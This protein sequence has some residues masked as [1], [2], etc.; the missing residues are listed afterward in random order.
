MFA[1]VLGGTAAMVRAHLIHT[2]ATVKTG[3]G[4][5]GT[6]VDVLLAGLTAKGG[7]AGANVS[8]VKG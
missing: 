5:L 3:R 6:F 4:S 1:R 2:R 8:G 7:R